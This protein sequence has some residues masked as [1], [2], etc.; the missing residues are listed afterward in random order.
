MGEWTRLIAYA[1]KGDIV[2]VIENQEG[3]KAIPSDI[4][5]NLLSLLPVLNAKEKSN[6]YKVFSDAAKQDSNFETADKLLKILEQQIGSK[7]NI[8]YILISEFIKYIY[9][10]TTEQRQLEKDWD[11]MIIKEVLPDFASDEALALD[12]RLQNTHNI[13]SAA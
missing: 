7:E 6:L 3:L 13:L 2:P 4:L 9:A 11:E 12:Q 5:V 10:D 1:L 8:G